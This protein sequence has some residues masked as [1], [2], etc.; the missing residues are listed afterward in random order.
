MPGSTAPHTLVV[1][2]ELVQVADPL[3]GGPGPQ[4]PATTVIGPAPAQ[5]ASTTAGTTSTGTTGTGT[6]STGSPGTGAPTGATTTGPPQGN[7]PTANTGTTGTGT[8]STAGSGLTPASGTPQTSVVGPDWGLQHP[9]SSPQGRAGAGMAYVS[10]HAVDVLFGGY[11]SN[12]A[13]LNDTWSW[14]GTS[15]TESWPSSSP[16][17]RRGMAMAYDPS[18]DEIILYGG[19]DGSSVLSDTWA[20]NGTTWSQLSPSTSPGPLAFAS[21]AFDPALGELVLFGGATGPGSSP[22]FGG[23]YSSPPPESSATWAFNGTTWTRLSPSTSPSARDDASMTYDTSAGNLVL[24]GGYDATGTTLG[25][26][27]TFDGTTW[28]KESPYASP[29][30]LASQANAMAY[31]AALSRVLLFGGT[32]TSG[33]TTASFYLWNGQ[34]STWAVV[35]NSQTAADRSGG[36][37]APGAGNGQLVLFSGYSSDFSGV[38][39]DTELLDWG[40]RG[41]STGDA[42]LSFPVDSTTSAT[43]DLGA[44]NLHVTENPLTYAG[45]GLDL[46]TAYTY[47]STNYVWHASPAMTLDPLPD[48]SMVVDGLHGAYDAYDFSYRGG[49]FVSPPGIDAT[50]AYDAS[51]GTYSLTEHATQVVDTFS[52]PS[53]TGPGYLT[54]I[55]DRNGDTISLTT[56]T[57]TPSYVDT[58]GRSVTASWD[59]STMTETWTGPDGR[60][61]SA[62]YDSAYALVSITDPASGATSYAYGP[63]GQLSS[64]TTPNGNELTFTYTT[65]GKVASV[66]EVTSP[67]TGSGP[68][69]SF[70]YEAAPSGSGG[71]FQTVVTD[72]NG[73]ASTYLNAY[74]G[75]AL[76]VTDANGNSESTTYTPD[77]NPASLTNGLTQVTSLAYDLNNNPTQATVPASG[78]G[79]SPVTSY[80][81]YATGTGVKGGTYLPS[82][83][84]DGEGACQSFAYDA[85]GNLTAT[86][87]GLA[88][89]SGTHNCDGVTSGPGSSS[90][91]NAYQGDGSTSCGGKPGELCTTTDGNGAT[92][93]YAYDSLGQL[94]SVTGPGGTCSSGSRKLCTSTTYEANNSRVASVTDGKGQVTSY[95]YNALDEITQILYGGAT[96]CSYVSGDCLSFTYDGN[97]N[98]LTRHD[99]SGVTTFVYDALDRLVAEQLPGGQNACPGTSPGAITYTYDAASNLTSTCDAGGTVTYT[100]DPANRLVGIATESGSCTPG[101]MVQPCTQLAYDAANELTSITYPTSTSMVATMGYNNAGDETSVK[102]T[103]GSTTLE[104]LV[105]SFTSATNDMAL[106]QSVDNLLTGVTT[107][108]GY[109]LHD[110]LTSASTGSPS[111]SSSYTYDANSNILQQSVNGVTTSMAFSASDAPC[112]SYVGTSSNGCANPPSGATTYGGDANGNYISSSAG[113]ALSYNAL[114]QTTSMMPAGGSALQ[115]A[116]TGTDSTQ[117]TEAGGTSFTNGLLG[118]ASQTTGSTTSWFTRTP[119]SQL[120]SILV[121]SS[122]YYVY[123]DGAGSIAGVVSSSGTPVASFS[124]T[125]YGQTTATGSNPGVDP[126]RFQ[127]GYEDP[128][129]FY[130]LGARYY[131]PGLGVWTQIDPLVQSYQ[132]GYVFDGADPVNNIDP[133][134]NCFIGLFGSHCN[135]PVHSFLSS[136]IKTGSCVVGAFETVIPTV[137]SAF[138]QAGAAVGAAGGGVLAGAGTTLAGAATGGLLVGGGIALI[139][140][141]SYELAK[142]CG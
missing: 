20:W 14:D 8:A 58:R 3:T 117:R 85:S 56:G 139:G 132:M 75:Q 135:N 17:A 105:Y 11:G 112:W 25:D 70:S 68:T 81:S 108:Y 115:M 110:R 107:S 4:P 9:Q 40:I 120:M 65:D 86:Y 21:M 13:N 76:K 111:T 27:W 106:R 113:A 62:Q 34:A 123:D 124:Y 77:R 24:F 29:P 125:P 102:V 12:G 39:D 37:L 90:V 23:G 33:Q 133:S 74:G 82:S 38:Y 6:T 97:G 32:N 87:A 84:L 1:G 55:T 41:N 83:G 80:L 42:T 89:T 44:G 94:T 53:T 51:S 131:Q 134:G 109:D 114:N 47:D 96:S 79:Q 63:T 2:N 78:A 69:T 7:P 88:P 10:Q 71:Q 22:G 30:P 73:H 43:V 130:K 31:D 5:P 126:F 103:D 72:P 35:D 66:T 49:A 45:T 57:T 48:G 50:L 91:T 99:A 127:G 52:A 138:A 137:G 98:V 64:L 140:V 118:L 26:T 60:S 19:W 28:T 100:Y 119:A 95:T 122:R 101:S 141:G 93:T 18:L 128:T 36:A 136:A 16:S 54:E 104:D 129:G 46:A 61:W 67:S 116:Y 59:P 15:W 121:G 92:T 142:E